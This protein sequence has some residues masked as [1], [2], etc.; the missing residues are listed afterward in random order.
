MNIMALL[1]QFVGATRRHTPTILTA[2]AVAG[3][4]STAVLAAKA[5]PLAQMDLEHHEDQ[6]GKSEGLHRVVQVVDATWRVYMPTLIS[7]AL[8]IT[9]IVV[10]HKTHQKRYAA[11]M[12]LYVIGEKAFSE[13]RES[14][15]EVVSDTNK[16]KIKEK[17]AEK[18]YKRNKEE[19]DGF[20]EAEGRTLC[21]DGFSG[22]Y[23]WSDIESL[24]RAQND[25]N[26]Q[27]L[28]HMYGSLNEFY[29]YVGIGPIDAGEDVGW[30][31]DRLI[32]LD[33]NPWLSPKGQPCIFMGFGDARPQ[34]DFYNTHR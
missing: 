14:V 20:M 22:R 5:A 32:D 18:T 7:G 10:M 4:V 11:L 25:F 30:S 33:F 28:R 9:T 29:A 13:Y 12:S 15:E 16:E 19:Q 17:V 31:S 26:A 21:Y 1:N 24:R 8:T 3:V 6:N 27:I 34:F 2:T 23:F